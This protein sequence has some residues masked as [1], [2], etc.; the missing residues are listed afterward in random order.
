VIDLAKF[1]PR[2]EGT[3]PRGKRRS[4]EEIEGILRELEASGESVRS[5]AKARGLP[6]STLDLW[7]RK[8]RQAE[9]SRTP[10]LRRVA[11][12]GSIGGDPFEIEHAA[13]AVLR[14]PQGAAQSTVESMVKS[15]LSACSR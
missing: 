5:F 8:E 4:K 1:T 7:R 15:F 2:E 9:K 14:I 12:V 10:E 3:M 13:G 6:V 11:V